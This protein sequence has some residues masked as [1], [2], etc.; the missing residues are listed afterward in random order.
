M[1]SC[2]FNEQDVQSLDSQYFK[3]LRNLLSLREK[4]AKEVVYGLF[5]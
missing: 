4:V 3:I 2:I 1:D 5:G